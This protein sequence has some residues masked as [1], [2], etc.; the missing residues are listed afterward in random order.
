MLL[1]K[2]LDVN[3]ERPEKAILLASDT[4]EGEAAARINRAALQE[5]LPGTGF[6]VRRVDGLDARPRSPTD[7]LNAAIK[8]AGVGPADKVIINITGGYKSTIPSLTYLAV[9]HKWQLWFLH[10]TVDQGVMLK[11]GATE[12]AEDQG[13]MLKYGA[14]ETAEFFPTRVPR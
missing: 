13:V 1:W 2:Y 4:N 3:N 10:E 5:L 12:T 9:R 6:E 11:Y 7:A 8:S 14:T